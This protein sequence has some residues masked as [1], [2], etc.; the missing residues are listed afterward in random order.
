MR[1]AGTDKSLPEIARELDVDALIEGSVLRADEQVRITA[2]LIDGKTDEHLWAENYDRDLANVLALLSEVA[3]AIAAE[4]E[5]TVTAEQQQ[6]LATAPAVAPEVQELFLK[7]QYHFNRGELG[8]FGKALEY[9][10][11]VV[12]L[13]PEFTRGW[14]TLATTYLVHGF[15]NL[16]PRE[17]M[18]VAARAAAQRALE[19]DESM[20]GAHAVLGYTALFFDWDWET[21]KR[22][23]ELGTELAPTEMLAYHAYADYLGVMGDCEGSVE[24]V[25]RG[26]RYDP[27]GSWANLFLVAHLTVC[28]HY[29][30]AILEGRRCLDLGIQS[31]GSQVGMAFW[32][33]GEHE[34]ALAR[35]REHHG[36]ESPWFAALEQG[37]RDAGPEGAM[38]A[39]AEMSAAGDPARLNAF[40]VATYYAAAGETDA[41]FDWLERAFEDRTPQLLHLTFHPLLAPIR[42]DPRFDELLRRIGIP[43]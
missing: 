40:G 4:I 31:V 41:A 28:G 39:A 30:E 16:A 21:A 34:K 1:Y 9:F 7:G 2:Q 19:L 25:R 15:F 22:E 18:I 24:Q 23:L 37:Y 26:R 33:Q 8:E 13:D 42:D 27:M 11:Q 17:E 29:E 5:V 14:S 3:R 36:P 43:E 12:E 32:L 38:L 35:W 6:R 10:R 20:G